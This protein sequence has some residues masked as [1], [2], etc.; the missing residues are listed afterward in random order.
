MVAVS[1]AAWGLF[2]ANVTIRRQR[3][4]VAGP[5]RESREESRGA[6]LVQSAPVPV[7][8]PVP[9]PVPVAVAAPLTL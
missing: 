2:M 1:V 3:K 4:A 6:S 7:P 5:K 9:V 8:E